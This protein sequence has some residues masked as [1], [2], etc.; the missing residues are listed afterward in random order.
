MRVHRHL[1]PS[2]IHH[3]SRLALIVPSIL[4]W[5]SRGR[6]WVNLLVFGLTALAATWI[7]HQT[8]YVIEY[9][10]RFST[11]MATTPHRLYM[12][13]TGLVLTVT[14]TLLLM[15][16]ACT[17]NQARGELRQRL[18][19]LSPRLV[20]HVPRQPRAI[21]LRTIAWTALA[22]ALA[23]ATL[24]VVQEN[25]EYLAAQ[26][27]LPWLAVLLAPQH[28]TVIPLHLVGGFCGSLVLWTLSRFM[29][30]SRGALHVA[31]VLL[32]IGK[33]P[34]GTPPQRVPRREFLAGRRMS[35]G[36]FCLR[37]PPL[38]V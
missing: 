7:V 14:V 10:R 32:G 20:R 35:A 6:A 27:T 25:L 30:H 33:R 17:L 13:P 36:I 34:A 4:G 2:R 15:L 16:C 5:R 11:V 8:E 19:R 29:G 22:L 23:Q 24:Y 18:L 21:P 1:S 3:S 26:G 28:I 31:E 12:A 9:G 38:A 37:S